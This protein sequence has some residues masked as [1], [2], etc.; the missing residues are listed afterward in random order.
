MNA[1]QIDV[2]KIN[3]TRVNVAKS[4]VMKSNITKNNTMRIANTL[5]IAAVLG[6]S[7]LANTGCTRVRG[8]EASETSATHEAK[9]VKVQ[10]AAR[11]APPSGLRYA[12]SIEAFEQVPLSFKSGGYVDNL[13]RR[14]G[15]D[16]RLRAAQPGDL[17][18]RG[19]ALAQVRVAEYRERVSQARAGVAEADAGVTKARADLD[20][21]KTLFAADS[22]IK[23]DLD[24]AQASFDA[25]QARQAAARADLELASIALRDCALVAPATGILM[26]RKVEAGALVASGSVGFV[27]GDISAV[28]ARFGIPD[29]MIPALALGQSIDLAVEAIDG[30]S[31]TGRVTAIAPAADAQSRVF[32]VEVTIPNKDGRL[33]P[34]MIGAVAIRPAAEIG[35]ATASTTASTT[36][37]ST[38]STLTGAAAAALPPAV[39]LTAIVR[40]LAGKSGYGAFILE[41]RGDADVAR[42]RQVQL[43]EVV[44]N[45]IIVASGVTAGERVVVSGAHLLVDGDAV[46][47]TP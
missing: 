21:A 45:S 12:A 11:V 24:A 34:G 33:R 25:A 31:F 43:G 38:A 17:V 1:M 22:L 47:V 4:N 20:R 35:A 16:G 32:D 3:V 39:P 15:A 19:T 37:S 28:K 46:R 2:M 41:R 36:A 30:A 26:E 40:S 18:T 5:L 23:P 10:A 42:L 8:A 29:A 14:P 13:L 27:L 6:T 7:A 9:P 44:G